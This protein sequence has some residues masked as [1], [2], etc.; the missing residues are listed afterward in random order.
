[1][2]MLDE[3]SIAAGLFFSAASFVLMTS[4]ESI[5]QFLTIVRNRL[6]S[7]VNLFCC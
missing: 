3:V 6:N 5:F 1:M 4:K 2:A 7:V